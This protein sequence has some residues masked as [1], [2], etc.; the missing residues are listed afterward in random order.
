[1]KS[2][3][4]IIAFYLILFTSDAQSKKT[5]ILT[6]EIGHKFEIEIDQGAKTVPAGEQKNRCNAQ[7][8]I[9]NVGVVDFLGHENFTADKKS[10]KTS[11]TPK[12]KYYQPHIVFE[13]KT[14]DGKI[15]DGSVNIQQDIAVGKSSESYSISITVGN[16]RCI[17]D[18]IP[19]K[20]AYKIA[21]GFK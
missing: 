16:R 21:D 1:M 15:I 11:F 17:E 5:F 4:S 19:I 8:T 12:T 3:L 2:L 7:F 14:T 13:F 10:T 18:V 6:S 20:F 9:T